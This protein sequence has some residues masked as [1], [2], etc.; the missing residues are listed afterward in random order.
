MRKI[1][2]SITAALMLSFCAAPLAESYSVSYVINLKSGKFHRTTCR[3]IKNI[4]AP[5]F[6]EVES[7]EEAIAMGYEP[8]KV[9]KP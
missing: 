7:R 6:E 3:T 9:C 2:A 1:I 5:H 8:C 4:D